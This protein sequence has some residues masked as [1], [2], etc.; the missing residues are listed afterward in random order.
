M[1][2][3]VDINSLTISSLI[4]SWLLG[5]CLHQKWNI[6]YYIKK[7][8]GI[9]PTK[10]IKLLDCYPCFSFWISLFCTF[11]PLTASAVFF[12]A[13]IIDKLNRE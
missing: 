11:E 3:F 2:S 8:I 6:P 1:K 9:H 5:Y 12:V 10:R 4:Y 13:T 7:R